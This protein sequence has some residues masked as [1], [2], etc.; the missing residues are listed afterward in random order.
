VTLIFIV[1]WFAAVA[2]IMGLNTITADPSGIQAKTIHWKSETFWMLIFMV[3]AFIWVVFWIQDKTGFICMVSAASYYFT[4]SEGKEGAATVSTGFRFAYFKH[5]GSLAFGS[6]VHTLVTIIRVI[7]ES[8]A[9]QVERGGD[10]V[11]VKVLA[12][13][14]RCCLRCFESIIEYINRIAFAYM[15]VS[16]EA[17][18]TSA[19]HGFLLNLKHLHK[20]TWGVTLSNMFIFLG[21]VM[22]T[23]ANMLTCY[24]IM[25][26]VSKNANDVSSVWS[27]VAL[28]GVAS[29]ITATIFLS[30]F[31]E[32][33]LATLHCLAIDLDLNGKPQYGPPSFHHKLNK[34]YGE[35]KH[36]YVHNQQPSDNNLSGN[37]NQ[38]GNVN[39]M[40]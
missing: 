4:S 23:C 39:Q 6:L 21:K 12:C 8:M 40:I 29:F 20:F 24:L 34:I 36:T 1:L 26:Y 11:A 27:P 16:G 2:C 7:V 17:Y 37:N 22:I 25:K 35:N 3:F 19:W 18:C 10:N 28:I 33:T 5:S 32:A 31:D 15:A 9:D 13:C 14:A 38:G 30:L